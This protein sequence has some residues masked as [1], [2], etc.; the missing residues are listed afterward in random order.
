M[1]ILAQFG[2]RLST[3]VAFMLVLLAIR[4]GTAE[5]GII[6]NEIMYHPPLDLEE[7][8][9][10]EL[11]N[12][13]EVPV[14]LSQ[15]AFTKGIN[16]VFPKS[17][18]L[19]PGSYLVVC[20]NTKAFA[21]NYGSQ[22]RA[23]GDFS[24][25]LSHRGEKIELSNAAGTVVDAVKYSNSDPWPAGPAG[26]SSSL[27]RI[28]PAASG[29]EP[30]NWAAS[31][32]P[33]FERPAGSP[34]RRNDSFSAKLPP[35]ISNVTFKTPA[36]DRPATVTAEVADSAGVKSV[37]LLWSVAASGS[38]TLEKEIAMQRTA[39]DE[40]SG[41]YQAGIG[42]QPHGTL[43]RFRIKAANTDATRFQPGPNEPLP[44]F[45]YTTLAN[46]NT[47]RIPFAYVVNVSRAPP[48][49]HVRVWN[50]H[51]YDVV[52]SPT[53]GDGAFVYVPPDGGEVLTFDHVYI[54]RRKGGLKVHFKK[55]HTF[56]GMTGINVIFEN[57]PRWLLS[58]PM[59]YELY[60]LAGVP[61]CLTE[62]VRLWVDGR[63]SGYYLL[64]EQ[65]NKAFL[66]R[67][68]RNDNGSLYK[69]YWMYQG[70]V[71]QHHRKTKLACDSEDLIALE[72]GLSGTSWARQWEFIQKNFNVDEFTGYYA[73]NMCIQNWDGFFNNY[74]LYHDEKGTGKWEMYPWDEDK[75][76]G[77]YDGASRNYDWYEMPLTFGMDEGRGPRNR[78]V[79]AGNGWWRPPGWFSGPLLA[80]PE[81]RKVF[82]ARLGDI[83][84]NAFTEEK[85]LP[86]INAL[87]KRLEPEIPVRAHLTGQSPRQ[88]LGRFYDDIQSLRN[89]VKY[90]RQF[91]LEQIRKDRAAR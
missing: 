49:S 76:W 25:K 47:A 9:Y 46:T 75:T 58:E 18:T 15:W 34:G 28:C 38:Q 5:P 62:H 24:G 42:G 2:G 12:H 50:G 26:H 52:S 63:L 32:L 65:P 67:N 48:Q 1:F 35:V 31:G 85:M 29:Q 33:P 80:N 54:R 56:K 55:E 70:L 60:R 68:A 74:Y 7:L 78:G 40:R 16:Y 91:I 83:C 27:E 3:V 45:S 81:F 71:N 23:L 8:Q 69:V 82:L 87:E 64:I 66:S 22:I 53:R 10:V 21:A 51:A 11:F 30:G 89:Q 57:S 41:V 61:A 84:T 6:I 90:R 14:D 37:S 86:L 72:S 36:P 43:V 17:T 20:R 77:D 73:V 88:A 59:A 44:S 79:F 39:G 13:G 4:G 19:N